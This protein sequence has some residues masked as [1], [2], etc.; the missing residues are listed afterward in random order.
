MDEARQIARAGCPSFSV[1]VAEMQ[2]KG[3]GR[4][5]R[6]WYSRA[7]GLYF[8]IILRPDLPP[9][10]CFKLNF[11]ASICLVRI[12]QHRY[13]I[14]AEIKWP[15]DILVNHRKLMGML[16]E[17]SILSN[18]VDYVN[19]GIGVNVNNSPPETTPEATSIKLLIGEPAP[20]LPLLADFLDEFEASMKNLDDIDIISEW[21][22]YAMPFGRRVTIVTTGEEFNGIA[23]N[24]DSEGALLLRL[25]DSS[26]KKVLYG[27]CFP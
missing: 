19:I 11:L 14:E 3:R 16:S 12:L 13:G 8:T 24:I 21:K 25:A 10:A 5:V 9:E 18:R 22:R 15:N 27:D 7:G 1:V 23:E 17:S 26:L 20:C 4:L 2:T 6:P